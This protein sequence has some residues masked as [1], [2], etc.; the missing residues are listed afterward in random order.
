MQEFLITIRSFEQVR[1]FVN[2]ATVQPFQVYV[3]NDRRCVNGK[4]FIG[5]FS[6]DFSMPV[7][8]RVNCT[9]AQLDAFQAKIPQLHPQPRP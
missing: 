9:Q 4:S 1:D 2:V 8:V 5:M 3:G 7:P 6:L